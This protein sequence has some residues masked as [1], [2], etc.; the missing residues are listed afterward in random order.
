MTAPKYGKYVSTVMIST[1]TMD[2]TYGGTQA[3]SRHGHDGRAAETSAGQR[4]QLI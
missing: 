1:G 4:P 3:N 2:I